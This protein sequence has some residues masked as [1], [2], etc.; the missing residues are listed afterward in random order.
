[1]AVARDALDL[2]Q[3]LV[4]LHQRCV[5]RRLLLLTRQQRPPLLAGVCLRVWRSQHLHQLSSTSI[6]AASD[7][8]LKL[9]RGSGVPRFVGNFQP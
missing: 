4:A 9:A 8:A 7:A 6:G 5:V 1:M 3:M 2:R